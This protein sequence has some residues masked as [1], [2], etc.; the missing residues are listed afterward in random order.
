M[1]H[2]NHRQGTR[3]SLSQDYVV[4]IYA[5]R[6]INDHEAGPKL[7]Q[8]LRMGYRY[9]PVNAGPART[10]DRFMVDPEKV[11][12][13]VARAGSAYLVFD[14]R[15]KVAALVKDLVRADLGLSIIISGLFSEVKRICQQA[16]IRPHTAQCS[17]GVWGNT[18][19]LPEEGILDITTMCGHGMVSF[20]L[21]RRMV[22]EV[23]QGHITLEEAGWI[24]ARP[25]S[26]GIFNPKRA[27]D[28][29]KQLIDSGLTG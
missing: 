24:L 3:E 23:R 19:K 16:R 2:T 29:L 6:G 4:F 12:A 28:L 13:R 18:K 27:R 5:A 11:V 15:E 25:C 8:F 10:G 20:N 9:H 1:T 17:L 14:D 7:Q 21:V 22:R 26:C